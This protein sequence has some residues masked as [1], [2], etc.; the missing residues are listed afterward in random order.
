MAS[1][2]A[3]I[4]GK[5]SKVSNPVLSERKAR[6]SSLKQEQEE[7][8]KKVQSN[9]KQKIDIREKGHVTSV[10][11]GADPDQDKLEKLLV[12][13]ATKGVVKLFNAIYQAQKQHEKAGRNK[14][15]MKQA[16]SNL[17]DQLEGAASKVSEFEGD[18]G[19]KA[20]LKSNTNESGKTGGGGWDVLSEG[21]TGLSGRKKLKD[22]DKE[23]E[24]ELEKEMETI[25][26]DESEDDESD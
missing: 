5:K 18:K 26:E 14:D 16:K 19:L 15:A 3:K 13:T 21:F 20:G 8:R 10:R 12:K 25:Q 11:Y 22:W 17:L 2:F 24:D 1:A 4:L 6:D 7:H 23:E 9:R